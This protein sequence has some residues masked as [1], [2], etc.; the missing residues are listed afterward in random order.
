MKVQFTRRITVADYLA[1]RGLPGDWRYASAYGRT[2]ARV[3]R[4]TY[5]REPGKAFR[6]IGLRFY[7]VM[8]YRPTEAHVLADAWTLYPRTARLSA[9]TR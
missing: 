2:V 3:Y 8:A 6:L 4:D 7:R 1:E 5:R 9:P